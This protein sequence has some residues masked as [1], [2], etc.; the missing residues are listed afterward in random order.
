MCRSRI[1][2]VERAV[3]PRP[4]RAPRAASR[5]RV[6]LMP[7]RSSS[8]GEDPP[9]RRVVVDDEDA[10]AR[11]IDRPD[12]LGRRRASAATFA[13]IVRRNVLP[14]PA[15]PSLVAAERAVHQLGQAPAD[16]EPQARPAVAPRD[17]RV[18]LA[19]RLEQPVH[20]IG[21][22][23]DARCRGRRSRAT[24]ARARRRS[25]AARPVT[26]QLDLAA[27]GELDRVRQQVEDD[28]PEPALRRRRSSAA[29]PRRWRRRARGASPRPPARGRRGRPRC[30]RAGR[31]ARCSRSTRPASIFEKSRMSLMIV[32]SASPDV[33]IVSA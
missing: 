16:R 32:S 29:G 24:S 5:S 2:E 17:R 33:R 6:A 7:Q 27:L 23:A 10:P 30:R 21:R 25:S 11:E 1:G 9:V 28:L 4:S 18:G 14:L 31:T 12:G 8:V 26:A 13:S 19:E 15:T 3:R 22:D 20:P